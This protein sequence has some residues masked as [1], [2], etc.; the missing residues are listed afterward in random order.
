MKST[1]ARFTTIY[2]L[3]AKGRA[4]RTVSDMLLAMGG[5]EMW[6][7]TQVSAEDYLLRTVRLPEA[8]VNELIT[9]AIRLNYG[10]GLSV[11]ACTCLT[12]LVAMEET[13]L[14]CVVGG[15]K[16]IP[17][18]ALEKSGATLHRCAV[19]SIRRV[20]KGGGVV[21]A[22]QS[23]DASTD[24]I[25][26]KEYDA[27]IIAAPLAEGE[28]EFV[29]FPQPIFSEAVTSTRYHR[30]VAEFIKGEID[31]EF[32]G[33]SDNDRNFPL[34]TLTTDLSDDV[35]F[36]FCSVNIEVPSEEPEGALVE[37]IRPVT[38]CPTRVWK[39]F[40]PRPL[41]EEEKQMM[42]RTIEAQTTVDWLAYPEYNP[43]EAF[44]PF[45][46][47]DGVFYINGIEKVASAMEMSVIG[48]KNCTLLARQYL[49]DR[50]EL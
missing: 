16:L 5:E 42:F 1:L 13:S 25:V 4:Y 22:V 50:P 29:D 35:P 37:Y 14:W 33:A 34:F 20:E 43:P 7:L 21:Y 15:N 46:L 41:T 47:D 24:S 10:Q 23:R 27:V 28:I 31:P 38:E 9:A 49:M 17:E 12:S 26:M 39:V 11:N 3:Q 6:N 48:A 30:T 8:L 40:S 44:P 32:F 45:V 19:T 18:R 2:D 36:P